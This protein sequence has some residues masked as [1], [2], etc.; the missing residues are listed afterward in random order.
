L[1]S[2]SWSM[3]TLEISSRVQRFLSDIVSTLSP[4]SGLSHT[5]CP[6]LLATW[7]SSMTLFTVKY[8][9]ISRNP[10]TFTPEQTALNRRL[11]CSDAWVVFCKNLISWLLNFSAAWVL[12][13]L[14]GKFSNILGSSPDATPTQRTHSTYR[15]IAQKEIQHCKKCN[16]RKPSYRCQSDVR[17][18]QSMQRVV[19]QQTQLELDALWDGK[20]V[21]AVSQVA[22]RACCGRASWRRRLIVLLCSSMYI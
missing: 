18:C 2:R 6:S 10:V 3:F 4:V 1:F 14:S 8:L 11:I 15:F 16:T 5:I 9:L 13:W 20:P 7:N 21:E 22:T 12:L 17:R 19:R